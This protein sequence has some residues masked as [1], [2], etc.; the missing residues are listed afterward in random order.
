MVKN[1]QDKWDY[2]ISV[3]RERNLTL[4]ENLKMKYE[5]IE[6]CLDISFTWSNHHIGVTWKPILTDV[7]HQNL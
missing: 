7:M 3:I 1:M 5:L 2:K 6:C 4:S